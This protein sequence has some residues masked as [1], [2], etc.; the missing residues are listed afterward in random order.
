MIDDER[1]CI[2]LITNTENGRRYV[3]QT[4][5]T[6]DARWKQHVYGA[7]SGKD[8]ALSRAIRKYGTGSFTICEIDSADSTEEL[9]RLE[10]IHIA[11]LN[12]IAPNGYN[13]TPGGLNHSVHPETRAKM[14]EKM[15]GVRAGVR[16]SDETR[17]KLSAASMGRV[18]S[19][20]TRAKI[21]AT[22]RGRT[23]PEDVRAKISMANKGKDTG[24]KKGHKLSPQT[25]EKMIA[26]RAGYKHSEETKLKIGQSNKGKK[27][28][29]ETCA[30]IGGESKG[31]IPSE[32]TRRKL[33]QSHMGNKSITGQKL[34]AETR[35]KI[36]ES[37]Y[38]RWDRIR[39][40]KRFLSYLEQTQCMR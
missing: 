2:Y 26:S 14:S 25:I 22:L 32:E 36:S 30:R 5:R 9:N 20:E 33:S 1:G 19:E 38:I 40:R 6:V 11:S 17:A 3:G 4:R 8:N 18:F 28:N 37:Q 23:I 13:L 24:F 31:R 35:R 27:R 39:C 10:Q 34:S 12:T 15:R 7:N 29:E 16:P 21:S